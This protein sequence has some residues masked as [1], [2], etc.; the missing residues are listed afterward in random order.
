MNK[1]TPRRIFGRLIL[2]VPP[3]PLPRFHRRAL[4]F[5]LLALATF[6]PLPAHAYPPAPDHLLFGQVRDELGN[7]LA[8]RSAQVYVETDA[9]IR[10][11]TEIIPGLEPGVNYKL[12]VSMD[13]GLTA[14]Q[15][16]PTA[17]RPAVPF[18]MWVVANGTTF[19]PI[20]MKLKGSSL[21]A[22]G[23]RT[24]IDLT[25]GEDSDG[26]GLPDAWERAM[27]AALGL[28]MSLADFN[29]KNDLDQD[30]LNN[31][32]EYL[33]GTYAFDPADGFSLKIA[34]Y[35]EGTPVLEFM[36]I[37]GRTYS[38]LGSQ[39]MVQWSPVA[40]RLAGSSDPAATDYYTSDVRTVRIEIPGT[41]PS[42]ATLK[43]FRLMVR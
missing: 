23:E 3:F 15:Y 18:K 4:S 33:A 20:E 28:S 25:L 29:P 40:F 32:D 35:N 37:R 11:K 22:P 26:D 10:I 42:A 5:S 36:G 24:R 7:P 14:D 9:G 16:K 19:L 6:W 2:L 39:D 38:V 34:A 13:S 21:G 1:Q 41:E 12:A 30:G 43:F 31:L 17:L 8:V 27:L